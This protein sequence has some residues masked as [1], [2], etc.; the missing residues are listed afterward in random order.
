MTRISDRNKIQERKNYASGK[1]G[2]AKRACHQ[3]NMRLWR[4]ITGRKHLDQN[5]Q[6][7]TLM[8]NESIELESLELEK[9]ILNRSQF[10]G[11]TN[12]PEIFDKCVEAFH[13]INHINGE[14]RNVILRK[15]GICPHGGLV[16]LDTIGQVDIKRRVSSRILIET[17]NRC[18][19][20]TLV[21]ANFCLDVPYGQKT[22]NKTLS[23]EEIL[24]IIKTFQT[25]IES[26]I[27]PHK[28]QIVCGTDGD[29]WLPP[30]TKSTQMVT[31]AFWG[32]K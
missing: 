14:W 26:S 1:S 21:C 8:H 2:E 20:N 30:K 24:K 5:E 22:K 3:H 17:L 27:N 6:Y 23:D 11:V 15:G 31:L 18:G 10:F 9:F 29:I 32:Y 13:G 7:W 25:R 28:W 19:S 12:Q 16:Y 4:V